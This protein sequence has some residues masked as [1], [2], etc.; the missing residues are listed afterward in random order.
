MLLYQRMPDINWF[1]SISVFSGWD[2]SSFEC[3]LKEFCWHS[4]GFVVVLGTHLYT[5]IKKETIWS[6]VSCLSLTAI[7]VHKAPAFKSIVWCVQCLSGPL[8][9]YR[10]V[11]QTLL[12]SVSSLLADCSPP[13][14]FISILRTLRTGFLIVGHALHKENNSLRNLFSLNT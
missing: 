9:S 11:F 3:Y 7:A 13:L 4:S 14:G 5:R 12:A 10:E 2:I 1:W 6:T 8:R